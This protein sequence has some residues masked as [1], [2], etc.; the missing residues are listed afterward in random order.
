MAVYAAFLR[1]VNLGK[2]RRVTNESLKA[3]F[4]GLG[5][6]G[7]A[8]FRASGNVVFDAEQKA[9]EDELQ[10]RVEAGLADALGFE[11]AIFLR[12][13]R[14]VRAIAVHEPFDEAQLESSTGKLQV[15]LLPDAPGKPAR[16]EAL[17][18]AGEEDPLAIRGRELYWLPKARMVESELDLRAL[19]SLV[20]PWTMRTMGTI[21]QIAAK[22]C[23]SP[24]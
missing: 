20:G 11:V 9:G 19:E 13:A 14:Q 6:G 12:S 3:A 2:N 21:E 22:H 23:G 1:G 4:E 15:A 17:A 18:L 10:A 5:L 16:K 7:V 24:S 8:T